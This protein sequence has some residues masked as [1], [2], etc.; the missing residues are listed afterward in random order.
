MI[1]F[2]LREWARF[3]S[4]DPDRVWSALLGVAIIGTP[5]ALLLGALLASVP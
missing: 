1:A 2:F 4:Q 5:L 3:W